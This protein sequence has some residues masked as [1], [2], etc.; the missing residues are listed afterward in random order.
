MIR[1]DF[2]HYLWKYKYF[3]INKLETTTNEVIQII[4]V[5]EQNLNSGPDFF[6]A[7]IIIDKQIWAEM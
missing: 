6:N 4:N 1:E 3:A 2:L 7:K 5:G